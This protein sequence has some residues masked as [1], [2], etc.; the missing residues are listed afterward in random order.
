MTGKRKEEVP[1]PDVGF[2]WKFSARCLFSPRFRFYF[3]FDDLSFISRSFLWSAMTCT[4][5]SWKED[6]K[7]VAIFGSAIRELKRILGERFGETCVNIYLKYDGRST[8]GNTRR[9]WKHEYA[10]ETGDVYLK[11]DGVSCGKTSGNTERTWK[12]EKER[13]NRVKYGKVM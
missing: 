9:T 2:Y 7:R 6:V 11:R 1:P 3:P 4:D 10:K 12:Y 8:S 13:S 5:L